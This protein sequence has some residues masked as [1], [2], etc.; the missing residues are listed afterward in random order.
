M[1]YPN[2]HPPAHVHVI[3]AGNEARIRLEPFEIL[4]NVGFNVRETAIIIS[5]VM[6]ER[7]NL[8]AAWDKIH[9][10]R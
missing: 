3:H 1:I 7:E 4:N 10:R 5:I 8:L 2:D 9:P 6:S